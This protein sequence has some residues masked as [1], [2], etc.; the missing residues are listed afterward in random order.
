MTGEQFGTASPILYVVFFTG[1]AAHLSFIDEK[2]KGL[3][4]RKVQW[5]IRY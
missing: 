4:L 5:F 2:K 3:R 1:N